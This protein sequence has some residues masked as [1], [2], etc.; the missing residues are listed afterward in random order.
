[1]AATDHPIVLDLGQV[2][3]LVVTNG[4]PADSEGA[5]GELRIDPSNG[6]VWKRT[7]GTWILL[8]QLALASSILQSDWTQT[9]STKKDYIKNKPGVFKGATVTVAG[10]M[11]FVPAPKKTDHD[12]FLKGDGTWAD[13]DNTRECSTAEMRAWLDEVD[14][15]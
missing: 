1:M 2:R 15:G 4:K 14:N 5:E 7:G 8:C 3:G 6:N 9:D 12:K 11:G 13:V 10:R